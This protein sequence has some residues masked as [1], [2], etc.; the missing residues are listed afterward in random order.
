MPGNDL[1]QESHVNLVGLPA[2][3]DEKSAGA[4]FDTLLG[5]L[6]LVPKAEVQAEEA[7]YRAMRERLKEKG[8]AKAARKKKP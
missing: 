2:C 7:K 6:A 4:A 8:E 5:K 1:R 3:V